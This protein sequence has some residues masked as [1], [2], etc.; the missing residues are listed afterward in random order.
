MTKQLLQ[1][2]QSWESSVHFDLFRLSGPFVLHWRDKSRRGGLGAASL[3]SLE[4]TRHE[5]F[6]ASSDLRL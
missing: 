4:P 5:H 1:R 3:R 2:P 6:K